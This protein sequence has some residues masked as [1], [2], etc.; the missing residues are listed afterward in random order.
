MRAFG[1]RAERDFVAVGEEAE[2]ESVGAAECA[3]AASSA[4]VM[5]DR[6]VCMG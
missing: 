4:S 6:S 3:R 5:Q 1:G 2:R